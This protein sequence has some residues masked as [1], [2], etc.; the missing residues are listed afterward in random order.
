MKVTAA[1]S[2]PAISVRDLS[3]SL[4]ADFTAQMQILDA[5]TLEVMAG[6]FLTIVGP[7]GCGKS[8]LLRV[9][10]G[11][12]KPTSGRVMINGHAVGD[13]RD[14]IG[15]MFQKDTL[16]PWFSVADNIRV[17]AELSGLRGRQANRRVAD[18]IRLMQLDGFAD[19]RPNRLS[20]GMRQ[21]VSLGR[22][23]AFEPDI[24]LMDEPFGALD[25][26]TKIAM[27]RELQRLWL[28]DPRPV[29][30]V[31]HDIEEAVLLSDRVIVLSSRPG[32]VILDLG[33]KF[34]HPRDARQ[35]R[36]SPEFVEYVDKVWS[37]LDAVSLPSL[38]DTVI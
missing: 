26:Q 4:G 38:S 28:A 24:F 6:E 34:D 20:G 18:L 10:S 37:M 11:L 29:L 5:I 36:R 9:L 2:T 7:S 27:G 22:L 25:P 17:G 14:R 21:R 30:F 15:F 8:T 12:I 13:T 33:I 19:H 23:L 16:L 1:H 35:L 31:T 32:R 3:V